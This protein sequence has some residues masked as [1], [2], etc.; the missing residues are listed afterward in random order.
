MPQITGKNEVTG[1][2]KDILLHLHHKD[3]MQMEK[4][5]KRTNNVREDKHPF[6]TDN[7]QW[8]NPEAEMKKRPQPQTQQ[9]FCCV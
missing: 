2:P 8:S 5:R 3:G 6:H 1:Q 4:I 7:A 9:N